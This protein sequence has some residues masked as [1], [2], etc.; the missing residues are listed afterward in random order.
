MFCAWS[1]HG[2]QF[3]EP[4]GHRWLHFA[5]GVL[6]QCQFI[7][8][9]WDKRYR[10]LH[11]S[12]QDFRR[13]GFKLLV[14]GQ[15]IFFSGLNALLQLRKAAQN[16]FLSLL[17]PVKLLQLHVQH[18]FVDNG[19]KN[20]CKCTFEGSKILNNLVYIGDAQFQIRLV[21]FP[22]FLYGFIVQL[23]PF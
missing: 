11:S 8:T 6:N 19:V 13:Q 23:F 20:S 3:I 21:L 22:V 18:V 12:V 15:H 14:H 16:A 2:T 4:L 9:L 17:M 5:H 7:L 1:L 10:I